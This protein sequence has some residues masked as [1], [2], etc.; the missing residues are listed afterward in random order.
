MN[1]SIMTTQLAQLSLSLNRIVATLSQQ[2]TVT[3][4][5]VFC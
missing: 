1:E 5:E 3:T 2:F 4:P